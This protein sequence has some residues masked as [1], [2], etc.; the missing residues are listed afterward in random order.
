MEKKNE[1]LNPINYEDATYHPSVQAMKKLVENMNK[2]TA[3]RAIVPGK[4]ARSDGFDVDGMINDLENR[5]NHLP[6]ESAERTQL[7][8]LLSRT[9]SVSDL[10]EK[11]YGRFADNKNS[12]FNWLKEVQ[13]GLS[14]TKSELICPKTK[15]FRLPI[16]LAQF[17]RLEYQDTSKED[18]ALFN[19]IIFNQF[20]LEDGK[21][22]FIKT[23]TFSSKFQFANA[24]CFE[25]REMGE[26][27]QVINNFAMRLGAGQTVDLVVREYIEDVEN[28]PTI[29]NGMPLRTEFRAFV[30]CDTKELIGIVPYWNP[31]VMKRALKAGLSDSMEADYQTYLKHEEKLMSEYNEFLP[32]VRKEILELLPELHLKGQY[33]IDVMKNGNDLYV[34]DLALMSESALTELL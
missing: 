10:T 6:E 17:I 32:K 22:Y 20:E 25:P 19:E 30:D 8:N 33:S 7:K 34:I 16:E 14:K 18:K 5:I 27:F 31:I 24:K 1:L 15:V 29:Y 9:I 26:Y 3:Q 12:M 2:L 23:G 13:Y 4:I 28:N 21:T 11:L